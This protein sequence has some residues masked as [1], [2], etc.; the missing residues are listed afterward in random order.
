MEIAFW[1]ILAL[2]GSYIAIR[3]AHAGIAEWRESKKI[4]REALLVELE[5]TQEFVRDIRIHLDPLL[6]A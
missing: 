4:N 6:R 3:L 2:A 1:I 5:E